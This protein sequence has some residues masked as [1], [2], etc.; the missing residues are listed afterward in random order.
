MEKK[1]RT[2]LV[3]MIV[4]AVILT[5]VGIGLY[6]KETE[7]TAA[8]AVPSMSSAATLPSLTWA[9]PTAAFPGRAGGDGRVA[10]GLIPG[11]GHLPEGDL[12]SV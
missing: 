7:G 10:G 5:A 8:A 2:W 4:M 1:R 11:P 3:L 12:S 6:G 9:A